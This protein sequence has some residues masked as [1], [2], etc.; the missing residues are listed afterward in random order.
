[1]Y[2]SFLLTGSLSFTDSS[3][4]QFEFDWQF[5]FLLEFL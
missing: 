3:P 4:E 5:E 1:M 2:D